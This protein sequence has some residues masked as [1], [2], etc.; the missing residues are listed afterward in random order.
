MNKLIQ[1]E[2]QEVLMKTNTKDL[3]FYVEYEWISLI[4][5]IHFRS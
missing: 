3:K 1:P 2:V 5:T 4:S